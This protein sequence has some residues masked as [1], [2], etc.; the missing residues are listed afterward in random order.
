MDQNRI[1]DAQTENRSPGRTHNRILI[2]ED[3]PVIAEKTARHLETWGWETLRT[4]NFA[5]VT[6]DVRRFE[7]DLILMDVSLP[8][9]NGYHWCQEIR[10]FSR[11]PVIFISSYSDNMNIVMAMNMGGDDFIPKPFDLNVL[12]AKIS[13]L[14][15][16]TYDFSAPAD[17][18]LLQ[19]R[20]VTLNPDGVSVK[21]SG[22][23]LELTKNEF[24]IMECLMKCP[25]K[26]VSRD[27]IMLALWETDAFIDDNTLTVNVARL[28]KKLAQ[29]GLTG[30]ILTKKGLG[31]YIPDSEPEK[32]E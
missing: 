2:T 16:R 13:A 20:G 21:F 3:D 18:K 10:T 8:F 5:D 19:A 31:Y 25:G 11:V 30:F 24:R 29:A 27:Q 32:S 17:E 15:R 14:M 9:F 6:A 1:I 23:R 12:T 26:V 22:Q 4:E 28:R 7:P